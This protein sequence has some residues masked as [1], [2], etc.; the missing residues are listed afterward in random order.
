MLAGCACVQAAIEKRIVSR[1]WHMLQSARWQDSFLCTHFAPRCHLDAKITRRATHSPSARAQQL[2]VHSFQAPLHR[3]AVRHHVESL[4]LAVPPAM[5]KRRYGSSN[6]RDAHINAVPRMEQHALVV[7]VEARVPVAMVL[8]PKVD[9]AGES[10]SPFSLLAASQ[11][12]NASPRVSTTSQAQIQLRH[13]LVGLEVIP[14]SRRR[15]PLHPP[16]DPALA[17]LLLHVPGQA[18]VAARTSAPRSSN[19]RTTNYRHRFARSGRG[20]GSDRSM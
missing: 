13:L 6:G 19:C 18:Q 7:A 2:R 12:P 3:L 1:W 14:G 4:Q 15:L 11:C 17:A 8:I 20:T 16:C 10:V 9:C 5:H